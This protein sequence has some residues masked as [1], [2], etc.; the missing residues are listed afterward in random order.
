MYYSLSTRTA[1]LYHL[2]PPPLSTFMDNARLPPCSLRPPREYNQAGGG[3]S[4]RS[5]GGKGN[6]DSDRRG[7]DGT[8]KEGEDEASRKQK[9]EEKGGGRIT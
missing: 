1:I 4:K 7:L 3:K 6:W 2:P 9:G 5:K 8:R